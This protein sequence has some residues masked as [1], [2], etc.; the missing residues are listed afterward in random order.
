MTAVLL[1]LI[2]GHCANIPHQAWEYPKSTV[3]QY[4]KNTYGLGVKE[5]AYLEWCISRPQPRR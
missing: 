5:L 2:H 3:L 4:A 1:L